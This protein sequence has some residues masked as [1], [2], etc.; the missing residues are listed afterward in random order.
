MEDESEPIKKLKTEGGREEEREDE[1][2]E[3]EWVMH[4]GRG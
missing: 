4:L 2:E 1:V 3:E